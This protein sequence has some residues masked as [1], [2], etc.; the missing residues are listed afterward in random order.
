M[1]IWGL[2][3][4]SIFFFLEIGI[5]ITTLRWL[6]KLD[7]SNCECSDTRHKRYIQT[8]CLIYVV[9]V[10][11]IYIYNIYNIVHASKEFYI[12][13]TSYVLQ[14]S[15]TFFSLVN[16]IVS[17][18]YINE[19]RKNK[20]TCSESFIRETYYIFNWIKLVLVCFFAFILLILTIGVT[21]QIATNKN[22]TWT[23]SFQNSHVEI[24]ND[25]KNSAFS[26]QRVSRKKPKMLM[27]LSVPKTKNI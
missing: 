19:L 8:W 4:T 21:Y 15:L 11:I 27:T 16:V 5:Y 22:V 3:F 14:F 9:V 12:G 13:N 1:D 23:F 20:C 2:I 10:T 7:Q 6:Y 24:S 25:H 18:H 17:I 26:L